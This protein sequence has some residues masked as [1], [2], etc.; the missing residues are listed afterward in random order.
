MAP[1]FASSKYVV[2]GLSCNDAAVE[3]LVPA[4]VDLSMAAAEDHRCVAVR[5]ELAAATVLQQ[6]AFPWRIN[7]W[8]LQDPDALRIYHTALAKITLPARAAIDD[9]VS[10]LVDACTRQRAPRSAHTR[11]PPASRGSRHPPSQLSQLCPARG[12]LATPRSSEL[13]SFTSACPSWHGPRRGRLPSS[14]RCT[15]GML[16]PCRS[17]VG[18]PWLSSASAARRFARCGCSTRLRTA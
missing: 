6:R 17:S 15:V 10:C 5:Y 4:D 7:R 16:V 14:L 3:A 2:A 18:V 1:R 11:R 12:G 9:K 13:G 8:K